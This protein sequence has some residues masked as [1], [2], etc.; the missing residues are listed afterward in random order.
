LIAL[1]LACLPPDE[2]E[3]EEST[4]SSTFSGAYQLQAVHSSKCADVQGGS[5]TDGAGIVQ[6]TCDTRASERWQLHDL[7]S[8]TYELKSAAG[9]CL[10]VAGN[11]L[12]DGAKVVQWTCKQSNNQKWKLASAG[13]GAFSLRAV[14]SGKCLEVAGAST[15]SGAVIQQSTC[16]SG[17]HQK[18]QVLPQGNAK[19]VVL[20]GAVTASADDGNGNVAANTVDGSLATRWSAAGDGQWLR[21]DLGANRRLSF[22]KL[23]PYAGTNRSFKFDV[24]TSLDGATWK[25]AATGLTTPLSNALATFD[26]ADVDPVRYVRI[27]GHANTAS[28]WNSYTEVELYGVASTGSGCLPESDAAFCGRLAK[29]CGTVTGTDSCGAPRIVSSCGSCTSP[30]TC[31]GAGTANVCGVAPGEPPLPTC[32]RTIPVA[33]SSALASALGGAVAGDCV[34]LADGDY[35]FPVIKSR[36]TATSPIVVSAAHPLQATATTGQLTYD[37]AAYVVVQGLTWRAGQIKMNNCDHCRLSRSRLQLTEPSTGFDWVTITGASK[38]CRLD[39]NDLGPKTVIGNMVMLG[40]SGSQIVQYTRI[41]HNFFHDVLGGGGNGWETIRAGLSGWTFSSA[42]TV[43]ERNLFKHTTGDPETISIKSSD[44]I[45]R[46]NTMRAS[47]GEF[48]LRHGNR[49]TVHGNFILG[50]GVSGAGGIRVLGGDHKLYNNYIQGVSS[51]GIFL[52]G[53]TSTDTTGMLTDHKQV[54][55]AQ[56]LF[57]TIVNSRGIT[58]G[59]AHPLPPIDCTV[60]YN[61]LQ[62]TGG[63]VLSEVT[64]TLNTRYVGNIVH[65]GTTAIKGTDAVRL[66]DPKLVKVG[67]IF[68]LATGSLAIDGA[69]GSFTFVTDDFEGQPRS[70]P[71]VGADEFSSAGTTAGL[72]DESDVGPAAP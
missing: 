33:S 7:G 41:D 58:L 72:L 54:Y 17:N 12:A 8:E 31:G 3:L 39:Y 37:G 40:G 32:K 44:N 48:T 14:H 70:K 53:G 19:L 60:A 52:E 67:E 21:F 46:Y 23:A 62:G 15:A 29:N 9:K 27:L 16:G 45:I 5:A 24:Q 59:G 42:Q 28:T 38:S 25:N 69:D 63:T 64:G 4:H 49:N 36:G 55:R 1:S 61:V 56:V 47:Q 26:F 65:D 20:S 18:W 22:V 51:T 10:D 34:V 30:Q 6:E 50:D 13:G 2:A 68:K 71:D 11:S 66:V 57:N 43:I 35:V